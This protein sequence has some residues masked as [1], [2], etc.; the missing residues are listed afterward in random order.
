MNTLYYILDPMCSWCYAFAPTWKK[1]LE[2]IDSNLQ[3]Q[4]IYGG[5]A[6]HS[7][8]L[9]PDDMQKMLQNVW[10]S[11]EQR[12]GTQF[13]FDFW[14]K[15]K[16][17]R[18]TY[19]ACQACVAARVQN[20]EYKMIKAIQKAYYQ[21]AS[22]P[23]DRDTLEKAAKNIGLDIKKFSSDLESKTIIG[24]F[25]EDLKKRREL[26]I[27]SFPSLVLQI[28]EN[29]YNIVIDYNNPKAILK[30]INSYM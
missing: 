7:D 4:Y 17:R 16:P 8:E 11:I 19:L 3:V 10:E 29:H 30:Q 20:K 1:I 2:N 26:S 27:N 15:C 28:K 22:N 23:S 18:S 9:M 14:T 5:L 24:L 6:P 25:Q 13:N 21:N 12:V